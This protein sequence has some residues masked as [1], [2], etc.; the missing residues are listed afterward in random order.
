MTLFVPTVNLSFFLTLTS[1]DF[2][3]YVGGS[4]LGSPEYQCILKQSTELGIPTI[5]FGTG[6]EASDSTGGKRLL[7]Y[8]QQQMLVLI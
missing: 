1:Y 6:W 4:I 7:Q 2:F 3:T 5:V 8:F